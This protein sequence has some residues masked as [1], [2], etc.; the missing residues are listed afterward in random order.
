MR[1][2]SAIASWAAHEG[3]SPLC[4]TPCQCSLGTLRDRC[5]GG[6]SVPSHKP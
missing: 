3:A 4:G 2:L 6:H 1:T 5:E